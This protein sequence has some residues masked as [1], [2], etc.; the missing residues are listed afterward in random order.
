MDEKKIFSAA[1]IEK[2][3]YPLRPIQKWL[4]NTHFN[5]AKSTMM[6]IGLLIKIA[7]EFDTERMKNVIN[8][9]LETY[10]IFHCRFVFHPETA[11]LCQRFDGEINPVTVEH[12][13]DEEFEQFKKY[14]LEPY[15]LTNNPLYRLYIFETP[16]ANYLYLDF[17]HATM[18]GAAISMLFVHEIDLRYHGKKIKREPAKYADYIVEE[19]KIPAEELEAGYKYWR[20]VTKNFDAKKHL[21]P[22]DV[23]SEEKWQQ[24][25]VGHTVKNITEKYFASND[26]TENIFFMAASMLAIAKTTGA[27]SSVLSWVHNGR[28]NAQERRLMGIM[29]EQYPIAYNFEVDMTVEEFLNKLEAKINVGITYRQSLGVTY[30]ECLQDEFATFIFQ[31]HF[32]AERVNLNGKVSQIVEL[33]KNEWSAAENSLDIEVNSEEGGVYYVEFDYDASR[34]SERSIKNLGESLDEIILQLQD[35]KLFISEILG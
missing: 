20:E 30:A 22:V 19:M 16:S 5:K 32:Y 14:L 25:I 15:I 4:I 29:L 7:P 13:S 34:Y 18:D 2:G 33:K 24:N 21:P 28:M 23:K 26:R 11:E 10:D 12:L 6:N 1:D 31:K 17:Y 8:E 35:E 9:I 27:K 3:F